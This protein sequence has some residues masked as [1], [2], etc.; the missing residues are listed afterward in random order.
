M[1]L[2]A[3]NINFVINENNNANAPKPVN[4]FNS[5]PQTNSNNAGPVSVNDPF[6]NNP[7]VNSS[8]ENQFK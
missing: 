4:Q 5:F 3:N 2:A 1:H 6:L 7:Q 8:L